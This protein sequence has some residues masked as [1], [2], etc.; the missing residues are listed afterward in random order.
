MNG[1]CHCGCGRLAPIAARTDTRAGW[2][3]GEPKRYIVGHS[4]KR[5]AIPFWDRVGKQEAGC[6]LWTGALDPAGYGRLHNK[7]AH[8]L[9]WADVNGPIPAG[10]FVCHH[11][12]NP[13]C[14]RPDHLFLGT[15][16][17]NAADRDAKGRGRTGRRSKL[18]PALVAQ[19]RARYSGRRGQISQFAREYGVTSLTMG[20]AIKGQ[21]WGDVT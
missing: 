8:R 6:W 20:R 7:L 12:D 19:L 9:A 13:P 1:L 5:R 14:V 15:A 3:K 10:L 21:S 16:A 18:T 4:G 17:D 11:C 2:I